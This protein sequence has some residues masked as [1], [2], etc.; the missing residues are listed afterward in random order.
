MSAPLPAQPGILQPIPT[1]ARHLSCQ[2]HVGASIQ[3]IQAVLREL[4]AF[5]DGEAT[6]VGLG[7]SLVRA[8]GAKVPGLKSFPHI[9]GALVKLP[10]TPIDLLIWLR[11]TDR[12]ELLLRSRHLQTLLAPA[13]ELRAITDAFSHQTNRDLSGYE[14]GTENPKGDDALA[15]ALVAEGPL[16]GSSFLAVQRW[17]HQLSHFA[18]MPELQRDHTFGRAHHNNEELD[19]APASA[20]VKRTA[21]E[22]FE[23]AAF[24]LRRAMPWAEGNEGGSMFTAFGR[25]FDAYEALLR[26]MSGAE[27]GVTDALFSFTE[28]ETGAYFWCPPVHQGQIDLRAVGL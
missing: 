5:A 2:L 8:L 6:V 22:D 4:A 26:R 1:Q 25:S 17:R 3:A 7:L 23:P 24:V 11:G 27:D 21:Q 20:H 19:D 12:G 15:A 14:D 13:F 28:P 18:A 9:E 10:A 16:A